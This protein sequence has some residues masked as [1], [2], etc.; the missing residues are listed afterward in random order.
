MKHYLTL[1]ATTKNNHP[2]NL[3]SG[4]RISE[5]YNYL[6]Q[7]KNLPQ[8]EA[9]ALAREALQL[10]GISQKEID[11]LLPPSI[12]LFCFPYAGG[13]AS[14]YD[15]WPAFF[16]PKIKVHSIEYP[17]RG[18][19]SREKLIPNLNSLLENLEKEIV[20]K[21][22]REIPFAFFGHSLGAI[23]AFELALLFKD[24]YDLK[25]IAL[26]LSG[27]PSPEI[28][29]SFPSMVSMSDQEFIEA[30]QEL[31]GT[32]TTLIQTE[33]FKNFFLPILRNDF[34]LLDGYSK[35]RLQ[36]LTTPLILFGGKKDTKAPLVDIEKWKGWTQLE[37]TLH[38]IEGD[39]FFI[40]HPSNVIE[41]IKESLCMALS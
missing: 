31:N 3:G 10:K 13:N 35:Q 26:F 30:I 22:P 20:L 40:H 24:K 27:S 4:A 38:E 17:G 21:L 11:T 23:I 18:G 41:K 37:T 7:N 36:T 25:P 8:K 2:A 9:E 34:S 29:S 33:E 32:P 12:H 14:I 19:K 1:L 39:H 16:P 5:I 15:K 6:K 28:V